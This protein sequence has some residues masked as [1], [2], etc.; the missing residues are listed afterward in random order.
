MQAMLATL[1]IIY[2]TILNCPSTKYLMV[3]KSGWKYK[4]IQKNI[5]SMRKKSYQILSENQGKVMDF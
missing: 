1:I 2:I 3:C 5:K 4:K